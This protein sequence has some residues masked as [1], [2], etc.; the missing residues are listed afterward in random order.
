VCTGRAERYHGREET[1]KT[2]AEAGKVPVKTGAEKVP[3]VFEEAWRPMLSLRREMDRVFDDFFHFAP[4][5]FG[6]RAFELDPFRAVEGI[7]RPSFPAIDFVEREKEY[8]VSAELPGM[9][10]NKL[11]VKLSSGVLI[12]RG[13]KKEGR[14]EEQP[15]YRVSERRYGSFERSFRLP[16]GIDEDKIDAKFLK[17]LLTIHLPKSEEALQ[18]EKRIPIKTS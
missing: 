2:E 10:E 1:E 6:R 7:F 15:S 14:K 17:G 4:F 9:D 12:I 18:K 13:E 16:E 11:E 8:V 5:P 3:S